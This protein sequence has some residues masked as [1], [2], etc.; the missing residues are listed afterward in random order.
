MSPELEDEIEALNSIYGP[1]TIEKGDSP[2]TYILHL[3]G[4]DR[5]S[6]RLSIPASY[7]DSPPEVH[8]TF[9]VG[10]ASRHV[11]ASE[12]ALFQQ[13]LGTVFQ[14]GMVCIYDAIEELSSLLSAQVD[15]PPLG[16]TP[17]ASDSHQQEELEGE[18]E[19][20]SEEL[21]IP[22]TLSVPITEL[23][24]TFIAHIAPV[25]DPQLVP[26]Y[27]SALLSSDRRIRQA[28]HNISAW[29]IRG[30]S[31]DASFQD[32]DDDGE[33]AA[34]G[35]LLHLLQA[36]DVWDVLVVVSRWYGGLKLGPR[37][38]ALINSAARDG[39]VRAGF[40]KEAE[41]KKKKGKA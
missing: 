10:S 28:T 8:S 13:A 15:S 27:I 41:E 29:R 32:Y 3:P 1:S 38:F 21:Q 14:P 24:S 33:T 11:A 22:W 19:E 31:S 4:D 12:L 34:G 37:R 2:D 7:P 17:H 18:E 30:A 5:S 6:L 40:V 35:R 16:T 25:S 20:E 39:L 9:S 36:M 23:K 26:A